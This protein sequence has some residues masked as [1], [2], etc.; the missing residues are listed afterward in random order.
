MLQ[1]MV[2]TWLYHN[3]E[4]GGVD[5]L[6]GLEGE[7]LLQHLGGAVRLVQSDAHTSSLNKPNL[8]IYI[9]TPFVH[10]KYLKNLLE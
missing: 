3:N 2:N 7:A 9:A 1:L 6:S 10:S 4:P 8:L 5:D